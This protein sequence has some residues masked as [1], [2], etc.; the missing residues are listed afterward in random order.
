[1]AYPVEDYVEVTP[2]VESIARSLGSPQRI[3]SWIRNNIRYKNELIEHWQRPDETIIKGTGDCEDFAILFASMCKAIGRK[4]A[5]VGIDTVRG[6]HMF[7]L[8][9][10][11]ND[12]IIVDP[13][14]GFWGFGIYPKI[15]RILFVKEV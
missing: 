1:M 9:K 12:W 7:D 8:L 10:E 5:I 13:T 6:W 4:V 3:F 15:R 2:L 14:E 11:G